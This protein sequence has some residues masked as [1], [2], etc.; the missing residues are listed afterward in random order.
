M[1]WLWW[2]QQDSAGPILWSCLAPGC[3]GGNYLADGQGRADH[4]AA[5]GHQPQPGRPLT[6]VAAVGE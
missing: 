5:F 4:A 1:S 3:A 6:P 2:V